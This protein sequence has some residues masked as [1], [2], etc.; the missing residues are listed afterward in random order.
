MSP[1]RSSPSL[2][3]SYLRSTGRADARSVF[4]QLCRNF[5]GDSIYF[6]Q[7]PTDMPVGSEWEAVLHR[8]LVSTQVVLA[9]IDPAWESYMTSVS[10][11]C[12]PS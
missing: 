8:A 7:N 5:D 3:I 6:D 1:L 4:L 2:F 10:C 9:I 12:R 11:S